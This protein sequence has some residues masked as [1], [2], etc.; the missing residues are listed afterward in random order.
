MSLL[1]IVDTIIKTANSQLATNTCRKQ[2]PQQVHSIS[3]QRY[4]KNQ[5][6]RKDIFE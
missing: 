4:Q 1:K 6:N 2:K 5:E 3:L